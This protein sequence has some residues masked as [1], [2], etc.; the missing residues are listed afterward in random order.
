MKFRDK[1]LER[2]II[3]SD[4]HQAD[5]RDPDFDE[6]IQQFLDYYHH[7]VWVIWGTTYEV[8]SP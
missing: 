7:E 8:Y 6:I 1:P 5:E 4:E 3:F 2:R